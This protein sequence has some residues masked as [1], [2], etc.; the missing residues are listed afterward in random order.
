VLQFT[1]A[2]PTLLEGK[3]S[4]EKIQLIKAKI[5]NERKKQRDSLAKTL[6]NISK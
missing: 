4:D 6:K 2:H 5:F 1:D 3:T